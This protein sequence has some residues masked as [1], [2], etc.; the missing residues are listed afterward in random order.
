MRFLRF[1]LALGFCAGGM[2]SAADG[3][4]ARFWISE[5]STDP[6]VFGA[7]TIHVPVGQQRALYIWAQPATTSGGAFRKLDGFSL[8]VVSLDSS[9][10]PEHDPFI[11]FVDGTYKVEN[12]TV[13]GVQKR[14]QFVTDTFREVAHGGPLLSTLAAESI[15]EDTPDSL[16]GLQGVSPFATPAMAGIGNDSDPF[17]AGSG[18]NA[19]WRV[20]EFSF[21]PLTSGVNNLY[22]QIGFQGIHHEGDVVSEACT[23]ESTCLTGTEV[24]FGGGNVVYN[25]HNALHRQSTLQ[26]DG[27]DV[28]INAISAIPGDY[29]GNGSVGPEDFQS[30]K[31][32]FG[33]TV[34]SGTSADG[35]RD[36]VVNGADYV[37]Y[38]KL[39]APGG[40][41]P[42]FDGAPGGVG[43]F[44]VPE[45]S[46]LFAS[47]ALAL[48]C[49]L[50]RRFSSH[51]SRNT[52]AA[53]LRYE[54]RDG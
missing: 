36:G 35:N 23:A 8:D 37:V 49:L 31:T 39:R 1:I 30:W 14:F 40:G 28:R 34:P 41:S 50:R 11:D 9:L 33:A 46:T 29:N 12:P 25:A 48:C 6:G 24:I 54:R 20:G 38:R 45:P 15:D 47:T 13:T 44:V 52:F 2:I 18:S 27:F 7:P 3:A 4:P 16:I 5:S 17:R 10:L 19:V 21:A 32:A 22:L 26:S 53:T 43:A 42:A 51:P